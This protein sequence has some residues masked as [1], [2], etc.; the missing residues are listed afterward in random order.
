MTETASTTH[1]QI[2]GVSGTFGSGKDTLAK[3]LV[4][5]YGYTHVS[6]GDLVREVAMR[7]RGSIERPVLH[8][9]A[10][11]H[12]Q[13]DGAGY[14]VEQALLKSR[15][16]VIS[17]I[18]SLGEFK[19][20]KAAGGIQVYVDAP[21][22]LRYDRMRSRQRDGEANISLDEFIA[23]EEAEMYGGDSDADFNIREIGNRADVVLSNE[24]T[25]EDFLD[26]AY[27]SLG[28]S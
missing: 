9:V 8:D 25:L 13:Q 3:E 7:E 6:T 10:H 5:K 27:R 19:S 11:L 26:S 14:F 1:P 22:Q 12:R 18:R 21:A 20:L 15:P 23:G 16:L 4:E 17:G 28:L 2:I 24:T